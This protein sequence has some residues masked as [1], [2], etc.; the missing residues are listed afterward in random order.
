ML[1]L[2]VEDAPAR[3]AIGPRTLSH[4]VIASRSSR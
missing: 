1:L 3:A 4:G 2:I